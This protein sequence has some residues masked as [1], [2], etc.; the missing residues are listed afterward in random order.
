MGRVVWKWQ[1]W[2]LIPLGLV[3]LAVLASVATVVV[4]AYRPLTP[5][6]ASLFQVI[7]LGLG[8]AGSFWFGIA[9]TSGSPPPTARSAFRRVVSLYEGLGR[10]NAAIVERGQ[11]LNTLANSDVVQMSQVED[12][13]ALLYAQVT[14]QISTADDSVEDWRDLAPDDVAR[15]RKRAADRDGETRKDMLL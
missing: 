15:L 8:I 5:L 1:W 6:E 3:G 10:I 13:L 4:S 7:S 12:A 11:R 2:Y 9:A 14:E